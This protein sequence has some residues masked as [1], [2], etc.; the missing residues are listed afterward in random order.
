MDLDR[1]AAEIRNA[2]RH[3]VDELAYISS[4]HTLSSTND[5]RLTEEEIVVGTI[6]AKCSQRRWRKDRMHRMRTHSQVLV[7]E[8]QRK[9]MNNLDNAST[10]QIQQ[11][12]MKAWNAWDFS[13]QHSNDFGANSFGLI[14]LGIIFECLQKL[15]ENAE[16]RTSDVLPRL[17]SN[18]AK[19][20]PVVLDG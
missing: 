3:Y 20:S 8:V 10:A 2:F 11:G 7:Q 4:T 1:N 16:V 9:L 13:L 15:G 12:L 17:C 6:L 18:Y 5:V 19:Q 14:A